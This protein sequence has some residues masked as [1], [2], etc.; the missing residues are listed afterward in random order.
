MNE[1][2]KE[3]TACECG[4][5]IWCQACA[6][7]EAHCWSARGDEACLEIRN[8]KDHKCA[9]RHE[10]MLLEDN[11]RLREL[12]VK[13][14]AVCACGC[15][16]DEHESYGEEGES[17]ANKDHD[18]VRTSGSV[19]SMLSGAREII[20]I[21]EASIKGHEAAMQKFLDVIDADFIYYAQPA[22]V[23]DAIEVEFRA[24]L[25]KS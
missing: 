24:R 3:T 2:T 11:Q 1:P 10:A 23:L 21:D 19:L 6:A 7:C 25:K 16:A 5:D 4:E 12:L 22:G 8:L 14:N 13:S 17:C 18:C 20:R 15:P 9:G